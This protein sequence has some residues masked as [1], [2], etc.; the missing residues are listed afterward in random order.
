MGQP[1]KMCNRCGSDSFRHFITSPWEK[2]SFRIDRQDLR[3]RGPWATCL[4]EKHPELFKADI[5][6]GKVH[7]SFHR[8][9]LRPF[10]PK[11]Q[12]VSSFCGDSYFQEHRESRKNP[13]A[14]RGKLQSIKFTQIPFPEPFPFRGFLQNQSASASLRAKDFPKSPKL[15]QIYKGVTSKPCSSR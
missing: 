7:Q 10:W 11:L 2:G 6:T 13:R 1:L 14:I 9:G 8:F 4:L 5:R 12:W 3:R 15:V